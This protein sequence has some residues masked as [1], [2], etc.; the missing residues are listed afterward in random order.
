[1]TTTADIRRQ[2]EEACAHVNAA[3]KLYQSVVEDYVRQLD[4]IQSR[5]PHPHKTVD[6]AQYVHDV[7]C[8]DCGKVLP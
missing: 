6:V 4:D 3:G 5:C 7:R 8:M 2:R 1:M